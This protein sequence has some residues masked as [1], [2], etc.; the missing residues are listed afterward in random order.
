M[1]RPGRSDAALPI[2][3]G[4][5]WVLLC[6]LMATLVVA[7]GA[8]R[9]DVSGQ[10]VVR[11]VAWAC[12]VVVAL[13]GAR[14]SLGHA[15]PVLL[16]GGAALAL[17]LVQLVPLPPGLW[18]ALPG[19]AMLAE[20]AAASGQAQ[21]WRPW[22]IVPDATINAAASL[23]VP[24]AVLLL[25][26]GLTERERSWLPGLLLCLVIASALLGL[27][28]VSGAAL[29]NP[30]LN[31]T[32][33]VVSG[34]FA[35][36]NHF[37]AFLALGCLL[38]PA[39]MF[40][41]GRRPG[42]R[43]PAG[44]GLILLFVLTILATGSR[45]GMGL[46]VLALGIG[47][48]LARGGLKHEFGRHPRWVLPALVIGI[49]GVV[50]LFVLISFTADRATSID[51]AFAIDAG[52]DMRGR[53]LPAVLAIARTYF[54]FGYGFGGFDPV[55]RIHEPLTLLKPTYFNH[56]HNDLL[57]VVLEA[58]LPGLALL[59]A[60]LGWWG[61]ATLGAWR[62][63]TRHV[64]PRLGSAMLGLVLIA[65]AFDYPARTPLMMATVVVAALWLSDRRA[66]GTRPALPVVGQHI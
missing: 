61:W 52:G 2:G 13:F 16:L 54:P 41:E 7:G 56:A 10:V 42:W 30:L 20:A 19:H 29:T 62:T 57:E 28:Q 21:P 35:N 32:P 50:A 40:G 12:L 4:L 38:V 47:F 9:A 33:G 44:L 8:S 14:P 60:A 26:A 6:V 34:S 17:A 55:F 37:A 48:V 1:S 27:L 59:L 31:E 3:F 39:W 11:G 43:G 53:A 45:A 24:A 25:A 64:L 18:Q 66:V 58:G 65:S 46:G 22:S 63:G 5:S 51:R 23:V 49:V 36:R 15:R